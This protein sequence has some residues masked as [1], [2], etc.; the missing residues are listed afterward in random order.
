[1]STIPDS[2]PAPAK[3]STAHLPYVDVDRLSNA[4]GMVA[5]ISQRMKNG[6][7]TFAIFREFERNGDT[8]RTNFIP[9]DM[10]EVYVDFAKLVLTRM[11][12]LRASGTLPPL[13]TRPRT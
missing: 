2:M 11:R 12:E 1:M 9:E 4:Y 10:G 3:P 13:M 5:I 8:E 6:V 7:L